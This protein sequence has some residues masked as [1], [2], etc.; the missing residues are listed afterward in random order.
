MVKLSVNDLR[1]VSETYFDQPEP[2]LGRFRLLRCMPGMGGAVRIVR[3]RLGEP[4]HGP[5]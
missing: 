4:A 1:Q 2:R 3:Y 5:G